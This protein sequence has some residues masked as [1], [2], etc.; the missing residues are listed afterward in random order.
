VPQLGGQSTLFDLT[1]AKTAPFHLEGIG[2][3]LLV[4]PGSSV[5]VS[6]GKGP[7]I[8]YVTQGPVTVRVSAASQ[9]MRVLPARATGAV[10]VGA[11]IAAGQ[12]GT[13]ESDM[14]LV[15]AAGSRLQLFT[16]GLG[17]AEVLW[18]LSANDS[19]ILNRDGVSSDWSSNGGAMVDVAGPLSVVLRQ[20]TLLPDES[21][22]GP[23]SGQGQQTAA[24]VDPHRVGDMRTV[25]D[26]SVRN[27]GDQPLAL[28]VLTVSPLAE[29]T[30]PTG[31]P[32]G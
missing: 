21:L 29:G 31:P 16:T 11:A 22:P 9:P 8:F 12:Q 18:V 5:E 28:Y 10:E 19:K 1:I 15:A 30:P 27:G 2:Y 4:P 14:T 23:G 6:S 17:T 7:S 25:S 24:T 20:V 26:G 3:D 13:L 32:V